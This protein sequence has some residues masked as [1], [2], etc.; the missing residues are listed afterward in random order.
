[1]IPSLLLGVGTLRAGFDG[2]AEKALAIAGRGAAIGSRS[3]E[4]EACRWLI[5]C[6]VEYGWVAVMMNFGSGES[7]KVVLQSG[8]QGMDYE[9]G[10]QKKPTMK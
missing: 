1:M 7:A 5:E 10:I 6:V 9:S 4:L 2:S 3:V 8:E